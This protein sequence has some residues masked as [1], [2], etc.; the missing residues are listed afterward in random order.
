MNHQLNTSGIVESLYYIPETNIILDV[1]LRLFKNNNNTRRKK[2]EEKKEKERKLLIIG[3]S[4]QTFFL[5]KE[6]KIQKFR[7]EP[8]SYPNDWIL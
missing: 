3:F 6:E 2:E 5:K 1:E 8:C 4:P 7:E